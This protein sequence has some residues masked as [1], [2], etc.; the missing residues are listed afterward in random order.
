[1]DPHRGFLLL[2]RWSVHQRSRR[3]RSPRSGD[4]PCP[5]RRHLP[6]TPSPLHIAVVGGGIGG[7]A[8]A[9]AIARSRHRVTVVERAAQFGEIGAG[10]QL[11]PN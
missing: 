3:G 6:V 5:S 10:L 9:L 4:G 11:A 1:M 2:P 7:L 8:A